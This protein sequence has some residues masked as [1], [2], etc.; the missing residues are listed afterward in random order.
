MRYF[1]TY[2]DMNY[3]PRALCLLDSLE[4]HC[5][6]FTIYML[7][8]DEH[9]LER[10]KGLRRAHVKPITLSEV[11]AATPELK[12]VKAE[13]S[14]IEYYYT[15]GPA[16][17]RYII[18]RNPSIDFITYLDAD[19]YFF[20]DPEPLFEAFNGHSI[21]VVGHHLPE[22]R[23]NMKEGLYNVGWI[24]F[25]R[26]TDGLECLDWWRQQC[27]D[28]CYDR[29]EDGKYADQLY[30]DHWPRLFN[31]FYEFVHHGANV[32]AWNVGDYDFSY[33]DGE[34]YVDNDPLIFYHFHGFNKIAPHIYNTNLFLYLKPPHRVLKKYA[35]A[36]YIIQLERY[37]VDKNPTES[38]RK[39]RSRNHVLKWITRCA[40]G[41]LFRQ[42]IV[43]V[44]DRVF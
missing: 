15:C 35:F 34:V 24:N 39:Y 33:R 20:N 28:W 42:Y 25:R 27:L 14:K 43:V 9:C 3:L 2:F 12:T 31:G 17:I 11:E 38:I 23:K 1:C 5:R 6:E 26:D 41:F 16:Y 8:L 44:G 10:I 7:C 21:G 13:R 29:H 36:E 40:I 19:L 32:A 18:Y 37:S 22:F 4:R 30:L